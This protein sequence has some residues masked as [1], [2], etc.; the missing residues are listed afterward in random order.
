MAGRH[1]EA[2]L[3]GSM[4]GHRVS[5]IAVDGPALFVDRRLAAVGGGLTVDLIGAPIP[6]GEYRLRLAANLGGG[7]LYLPRCVR[8]TVDGHPA[9]GGSRIV[10]GREHWPRMRERLAARVALPVE[11]PPYAL[12]EFAVRPVSLRITV[13]IVMGGFTIYQ[14]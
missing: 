12:E 2:A 6:P 7:E 9:W 8:W 14:L 5:S 3:Q 13:L 4:L 1:G 10:T 11:L